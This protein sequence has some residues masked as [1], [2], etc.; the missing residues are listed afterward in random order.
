MHCQ[1]IETL[2]IISRSNSIMPGL[3]G[4]QMTT[5]L[6]VTLSYLS[7]W[8]GFDII[9]HS[10]VGPTL[11]TTATVQSYIMHHQPALCTTDLHCAPY[12][13]QGGIHLFPENTWCDPSFSKKGI[14]YAPWCTMHFNG[15]Q[16]SSVV[17]KVDL[18]RSISS[19]RQTDRREDAT[20]SL[21]QSQR[22]LRPPRGVRPDVLAQSH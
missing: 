3:K 18:D 4:R 21:T 1:K 14:P 17:H 12:R 16:C 7:C 13:A 20:K 6:T 19:D 15:G 2:T 22:D 10:N 8:Y 5:K 9:G 11:C